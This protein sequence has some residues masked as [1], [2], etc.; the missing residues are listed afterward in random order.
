MPLKENQQH[1]MARHTS[2]KFVAEDV[3]CINIRSVLQEP[4]H[5]PPGRF[6]L[7]AFELKT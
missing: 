5:T 1:A 4:L 7:Y 6:K 2:P 3:P